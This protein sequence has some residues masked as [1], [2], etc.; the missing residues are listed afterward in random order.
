MKNFRARL[1]YAT[2]LR[3]VFAALA[4]ALTVVVVMALTGGK[5]WATVQQAQGKPYLVKVADNAFER[6]RGLSGTTPQQLGE[7][8][9]MLFVFDDA[10]ARTFWMNGMRYALDI[11]WL[12]DGKVVRIDYGVLAPQPG[13]EPASVTSEPLM[14]DMVLEVPAGVAAQLGYVEGHN[15]VIDFDFDDT[16]EETG[17]ETAE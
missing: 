3:V 14:V 5:E 2:L 12:K 4:V 13:E 6:G 8:V 17:E 9:G 15:L 7:A 10:E 1:T 16:Q 11:L